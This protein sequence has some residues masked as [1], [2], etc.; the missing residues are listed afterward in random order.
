MPATQ[1][2]RILSLI[3]PLGPD[4]LTLGSFSGTEGMSRLFTYQLQMSSESATSIE[5]KDI[6]GKNV[7]WSVQH[8]DAPPRFFNGFVS[9]FSGG[10]LSQRNARAYRAQVVPWLWF[11][12]RTA[13]CRIFQNKSVPE[14]VEQVFK[15]L[16]FSDYVLELNATYPKREYC[17]QYRET[18]FNFVSRLHG[19]GRHLLF[20]P[21]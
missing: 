20:L 14:I 16:G 12:T 4:V 1:A 15:D 13:N 10:E 11:L 7:T 2:N 21:A 17:V 9:R 3:T 8:K 5:P 18:A 19:R 6:V